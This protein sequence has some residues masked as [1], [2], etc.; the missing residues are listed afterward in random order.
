MPFVKHK[1]G[2]THYILRG[3]SKKESLPY[4]FLHGGPG[5]THFLA[6]RHL[7]LAKD[8]Q[9]ILYDQ[10]GSYLSK[11]KSKKPKWSIELFVQEL[12]YLINH[13]GLKQFHLAGGSWGATLA[14][15][16][17][18]RKKDPRIATITFISPLFSTPIWIQDAKRLLKKLPMKTQKVI[19]VCQ[20]I[21]A[22][23]SKVYKQAEME[24]NKRFVFRGDWKSRSLTKAFGAF[25]KEVYFHMWGPSEFHPTGKLKNYDRFKDLSK[26]KVPA[27]IF[28]GQY[29]EATPESCKKFRAKMKNA[30]L[31]ILSGCSHV[32]IEE[33]PKYVVAKLKKW[34]EE[35]DRIANSNA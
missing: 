24:F 21:G 2:R 16:Y 19:E 31:T 29:D 7:E 13:L 17:Y 26:V 6:L 34:L 8:R 33:R 3:K 30:K 23:D 32:A 10:L 15:E 1:L 14:L 28:C 5:S 20:E 27:H 9:I 12:E 18:L 35:A 4:I 25:N 22:T 11:P